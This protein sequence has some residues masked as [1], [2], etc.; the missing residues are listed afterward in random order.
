VVVQVRAIGDVVRVEVADTGI[1]IEADLQAGLFEP[2]A[3]VAKAGFAVRPGTGLGLAIS[4]R[5]VEAMGGV[6]GLESAPGQG[7]RFWFVLPRLP[8]PDI[9]QPC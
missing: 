1:G 6:M 9:G 3:R 7:S 4:R 5:L 2:L 8:V